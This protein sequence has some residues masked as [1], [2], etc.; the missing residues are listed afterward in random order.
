M[1]RIGER[2]EELFVGAGIPVFGGRVLCR[3]RSW[4]TPASH[5]ALE[6]WNWIRPCN[7][8]LA[9]PDAK[10]HYDAVLPR[11]SPTS[12]RRSLEWISRRILHYTEHVYTLSGR[13]TLSR[14][15]EIRAASPA[16]ARNLWVWIPR[17]SCPLRRLIRPQGLKQAE[18]CS[19]SI[20]D[21][22]FFLGGGVSGS[23]SY[24][25]T[26]AAPVRCSCAFWP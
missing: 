22:F 24:T 6:N 26:P 5:M 21:V 25:L 14:D 9:E 11:T 2:G 7:K 18:S 13:C 19:L 15:A 1:I 8:C 23:R 4:K 3:L 20:M 10:P 17:D 16:L 12:P